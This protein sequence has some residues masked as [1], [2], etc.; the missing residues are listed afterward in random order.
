MRR[1][2]FLVILVLGA[3]V[4]ASIAASASVHLKNKPP[5]TFND[6]GLFLN[7]TGAL[8]GL[9]NGDIVVQLT[10][11]GQPVST[12]TNPAGQTQP[13][14]QNPAEVEL[15]GAQEIPEGAI[16]NGN[17]GFDVDTASPETPIPG[18]PDCPN[19]QWTEDISDVIFS[20]FDATITVFQ[21]IGCAIDPSTGDP[22]AN[23]VQVF[24]VTRT[25]P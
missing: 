25:V 19:P 14:G 22:N 15:G 2:S 10:A 4:T 12:C 3:L 11:T 21:G 6:Q 5:L 9:G 20:G 13:P 16:K 24:T 7:A 18:A 8:T 1:T 17:V 23:C